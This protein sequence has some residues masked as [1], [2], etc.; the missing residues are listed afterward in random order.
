MS[1]FWH[2]FVLVITVASMIGALW[3]LFANAKG[4][5]TTEDTGHVWDGDLRE[6][7]NPLPR[8][9]LNL[10][11]ITVV[12]G[13][14]YFVFYPGLGNFGGTYGWTSDKQ[15]EERL[16]AVR[17]KR[18]AVFAQFRDQD[19]G[20]LSTNA[21]ALSLGRD[22]FL[23][24]CAGCHGAD[25]RGAI[26]FP[27]LTDNDWL[28]GGTPEQ[29]VAS[30]TH[31]R[32]GIMPAF[33][34]AIDAATVDAL[35]QTVARWSDPKLDPAVRAKGTAQFN[36]TCA[37]CHGPDGKGNPMLGAPNLTDDIWLYGGTRDR[38]RET[39]LFGR[40]GAMPAHEKLLRPDEIKVVAA[41][42]LSLSKQGQP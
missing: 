27:N 37:A 25:A 15:L 35:A 39:I 1:G 29:V 13:V 2:W 32:N 33:N 19:P 4:K 9:W 5:V 41:Y 34:G 20:S 18:D 30:I 40:K 21:A 38:V 26:G 17:A 16:A 12:F 6:Y 14:A 31:G 11:V 22:V 3:L 7:N 24:N 23:N 36:I 28:Y 42:V 10:F 8:W